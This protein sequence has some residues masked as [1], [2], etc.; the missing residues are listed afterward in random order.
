MQSDPIY[1]AGIL[2]RATL[3]TLASISSRRR[4][5]NYDGPIGTA[6]QLAKPS[7]YLSFMRC[8]IERTE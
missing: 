8:H 6:G 2:T 1:G 5:V 7:S 3:Y 4:T